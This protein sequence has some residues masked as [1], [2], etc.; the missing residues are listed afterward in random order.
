[1]IVHRELL[2]VIIK[3]PRSEVLSLKN[4]KK[5]NPLACNI[6]RVSRKNSY[7][8]FHLLDGMGG[9]NDIS[10]INEANISFMHCFYPAILTSVIPLRGRF[11]QSLYLAESVCNCL[12]LE[13]MKCH[14]KT[15]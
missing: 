14:E 13:G 10:F 4:K 15:S 9:R 3:M 6:V 7:N 12:L 8:V 11:A 5:N 2:S 1:M